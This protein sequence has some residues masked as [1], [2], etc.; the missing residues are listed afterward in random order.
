MRSF[1]TCI[2]F[3]MLVAPMPGFGQSPPRTIHVFVALAD[4]AH[5][6]IA[7]VPA[8]I[9][10]GDDPEHNLYWGCD[11][12]LKAYFKKS[13][14]WK[15]VAAVDPRTSAILERCVFRHATANAYL[16]ADA[17][18]GR[19]IKAAIEDFLS[20]AAGARPASIKIKNGP[21][22]KIGGDSDLVA[23]IG[24]NG[25]MDFRIADVQSA[26]PAHKPAIVLCCKSRDYF[27]EPLKSAGAAPLLLTTQL[28]YPGSFI[29]KA[30][31]DGWLAGET[32]AQI[33]KRA[34]R[35]YAKN[36]QISEKS[37][38]GVFVAQ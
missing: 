3:F 2:C 27:A 16:V 17:Y 12:G 6:G 36:Q 15:F 10:N 8:K 1:L 21:P 26:R 7:P 23:Y 22:L 30:A 32:P 35:A 11:E 9:G 29:L 37:A 20:A 28:M 19:D 14:P 5:Q 31:L 13:G 4:N 18:R 24:H 33:R 25:L 38:L 34:G